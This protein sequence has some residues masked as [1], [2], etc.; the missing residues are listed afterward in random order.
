MKTHY[1]HTVVLVLC[2]LIFGA[3]ST[4]AQEVP[5]LLVL[6]KGEVQ[7]LDTSGQRHSAQVGQVVSTK[8]FPKV[9]LGGSA[10]LFLSRGKRLIELHDRGEYEIETLFTNQTRLLTDAVSF[11]KQL[12]QPRIYSS[13]VLTR[14]E[15][16]D[17][18]LTDSGY[19]EALWSRLVL[20]AEE[21]ISTVPAEDLL[22]AAAWFAQREQKARVAF[23]LE[24][25]SGLQVGENEFYRQMRMESLRGVRLVDINRELETT[26]NQIAAGRATLHY[27]ALLIGI[28][29][30]VHPAWQQL[31]NP[32][33]DIRALKNVL[34]S[35]Y[36]F[37][38]ED[39]TLLEN[40][41]YD[42]IIEAF[43]Q[44]KRFAGEDTSLL[45]YYA[46]HGYYPKDEGEG[47]W[48]PRDAG[49]PESLRLFL[50]TSTVL[51][52]I[53]SI[54]TRHTLLI[55]D[56]C[57]SGA[58]VRKTRGSE[59][60]SRFY[61][62]LSQ[63]KSRQIITS[64]GLEPVDDQGAG[65]H[66]IFAGKLIQILSQ[67]RQEPLSASEL[68]FN[69]RKEVKN[70]WGDQT[71][72]YGR[73]QIADDENGEFFFVQ[74]DEQTPAHESELPRKSLP[75][76]VPPLPQLKT[77][78]Y[79]NLPRGVCLAPKPFTDLRHCSFA[80][81]KINEVNL[82]GANLEGVDF[83]YA[84]ANEF[85]LK[86]ANL[87]KTDW[88]YST[89]ND[90]QADGSKAE[91]SDWRYSRINE[92]DLSHS[93]LKNTDF[94]YANLN[95]VNLNHSDLTG[96]DLRYATLEDVSFEGANLTDVNSTS[97]EL[98]GGRINGI[99]TGIAGFTA[100]QFNNINTPPMAITV[101]IKP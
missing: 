30:Y 44:L 11:L 87:T 15:P 85:N 71:P 76:D 38:A 97:N 47:Y 21:Q 77:R 4:L 35:Q 29:T 9:V 60:N 100:T 5:T 50:P 99:V 86:G 42:D 8:Q 36:R 39:V 54:K 62:D 81:K 58:L 3:S 57:F 13:A 89:L 49:E 31:K 63:K 69:L 14:G 20:E 17:E 1:P 82:E 78:T 27:K 64:G 41:S 61:Q 96:A 51:S 52:K 40:A 12:S 16:G 66:S 56:S 6:F 46:G 65:P 67:E 25:L 2:C 95:E 80:F 32:V 94:R 83:K 28:N 93:N 84:T 90:L 19:F 23:I 92:C 98:F 53:H 55:A 73:L 74:L 22:A 88:R 26:R 48:I 72:E 75:A 70:A 34:V 79:T 10:T 18:A 45:V 68:A 37:A 24:R 43:N 7:L 91:K 33:S 101:P 59:G